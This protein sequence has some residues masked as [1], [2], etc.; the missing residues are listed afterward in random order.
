M[1]VVFFRNILFIFVFFTNS[2]ESSENSSIEG[3]V[4]EIDVLIG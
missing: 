4:I 2:G 1:L 3:F